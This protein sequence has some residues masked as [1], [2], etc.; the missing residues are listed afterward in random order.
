MSLPCKP[1]ASLDAGLLGR[2]AGARRVPLSFAPTDADL[3]VQAEPPEVHR[4]VERLALALGAGF[5]DAPNGSDQD[6]DHGLPGNSP[7]RRVAFTVRLDT[8]RHGQLR[9][10]AVAQARSAQS[11][12]I[13]A[14]D[15]FHTA[16]AIA[17]TR[18]ATSVSP[19]H[20]STGNSR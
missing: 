1:I 17:P 5:A 20:R 6:A 10:I 18:S 19:H 7:R 11:V 14:L 3:L 8:A 4:Q 2:R 13:E 16:L 9:Q 12:V 15:L